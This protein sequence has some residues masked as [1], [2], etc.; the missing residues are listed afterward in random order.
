[1]N[2]YERKNAQNFDSIISFIDYL[3]FI[4]ENQEWCYHTLEN[5]KFEV[6]ENNQLVM[7]IDNSICPTLNG[8]SENDSENIEI[9]PVTDLAVPSLIRRAEVTG[10]GIERLYELNKSKFCQHLEDYFDTKRTARGKLVSC[11]LFGNCNAVHSGNY[12]PVSQLEF[13]KAVCGYLKNSFTDVD[14]VDG[15]YSENITDVL[16]RID[17]VSLTGAYTAILSRYGLGKATSCMAKIIASDIGEASCICEPAIIC[18]NYYIPLGNK[19][20]IRHTGNASVDKAVE[21][22]GELFAGFTAQVRS[23]EI[24]E[25]ISISN[26]KNAMIK[27]F[28]YLK[29][30]QK[31]ASEIVESFVP[32]HNNAL[33]I[34]LAMTQTLNKSNKAN[35]YEALRDEEK[36]A[37]LLTISAKK[38]RSFD[39][40]GVVAWNAKDK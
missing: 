8:D 31:E 30:P 28:V 25:D 27:A 24:L 20:S 36:L 15:T 16:V 21:K 12:V 35:P 11:V 2:T 23:L 6:D 10:D 39:V 9:Y 3:E 14:F 33:E 22:I 40:S 17:D 1:M 19:L 32:K 7:K 34:Y 13:F 29:F 37:R 5:T 26:A 38:W 4:E 18:D